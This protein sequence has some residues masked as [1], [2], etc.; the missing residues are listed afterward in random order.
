M[1]G[2]D[3]MSPAPKTTIA[4]PHNRNKVS[5]LSFAAS[6]LVCF[7]SSADME[8]PFLM[9]LQRYFHRIAAQNLRKQRLD[10][11]D[12]FADPGLDGI[13]Q[14]KHALFIRAKLGWFT[15]HDKNPIGRST[16][17]L[18]RAKYADRI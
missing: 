6:P 13:A 15:A 4:A 9:Q 12:R 5:L 1:I 10:H 7:I 14:T 17:R 18:G 11:D 2:V 3:R 8:S 16:H